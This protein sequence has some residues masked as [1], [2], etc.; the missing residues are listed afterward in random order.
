MT[1]PLFYIFTYFPTGKAHW[2]SRSYAEIVK[3]ESIIAT[4]N[5]SYQGQPL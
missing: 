5:K 2:L 4:I 1:R 3:V